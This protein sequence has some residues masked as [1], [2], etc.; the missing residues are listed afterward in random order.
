MGFAISVLEYPETVATFWKSVRKFMVR[1]MDVVH[2]PNALP[3]LTTNNTYNLCHFWS[4]F[5]IA[6]F[7]FYRSAEYKRF[8]DFMDREGGI[9]YERWAEAPLRTVAAAMLMAPEQI[10]FFNDVGYTVGLVTDGRENRLRTVP[11]RKS[12]GKNATVTP[13]RIST[14]IGILARRSGEK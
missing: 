7:G 4:N 13:V 14:A 6:S 1:N 12:L 10:H 8:F 9:Y 3:W 11:K 5:E 2:H